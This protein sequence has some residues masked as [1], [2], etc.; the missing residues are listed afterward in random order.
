MLPHVWWLV[1]K[2]RRPPVA[3]RF[4]VLPPTSPLSPSSCGLTCTDTEHAAATHSFGLV[5]RALSGCRMVHMT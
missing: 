3:E 2:R 4:S 1:S 5:R